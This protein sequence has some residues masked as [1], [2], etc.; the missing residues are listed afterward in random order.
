MN[1]GDDA[2]TTGAICGQFAG[3]YWG[4]GKIPQE[5]RDGLAKQEMI[6]QALSGLIQGNSPAATKPKAESFLIPTAALPT[7]R[8]YWVLAGKFLAGAYPGSPDPAM[9]QQRLE[10]LWNAGMRTFVN[11]MEENETNNAGQPFTRYDDRLRSLALNAEEQVAHLRFSVRDLSVPSAD[12]MRSILDAIDL[13][14]AA[15]RPVYLH[16][17]GG[18]GRTGTTVCCWLLRHGL[19]NPNDVIS[20]L[21][22]LRQADQ[23]TKD[24]KAPENSEQIAFVE[25]WLDSS[26]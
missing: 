13:S 9:H 22:D 6:E 1:L 17:F 25:N 23:Q 18:V 24:R 12:G 4:E 2:D 5:W 26:T 10:E 8:C 21:R 15:N 20:V 3:A 11:L 14:L 19:A 7:I 16:C